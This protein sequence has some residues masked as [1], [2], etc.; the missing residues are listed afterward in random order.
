MDDGQDRNELVAGLEDHFVG[1]AVEERFARTVLVLRKREGLHLDSVKQ[2]VEFVE[3]GFGCFR[4]ALLVILAGFDALPRQPQR[5]CPASM[6][7]EAGPKLLPGFRP[8]DQCGR[9]VLERFH[10]ATDLFAP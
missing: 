5:R 9:A 8:R 7:L 1:E 10:A 3:E 6:R 4:I 2:P